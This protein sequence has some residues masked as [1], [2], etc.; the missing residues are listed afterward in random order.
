MSQI[1]DRWMR[2]MDATKERRARF[3]TVNTRGWFEPDS[4]IGMGGGERWREDPTSTGYPQPPVY[5]GRY[6][7]ADEE[8][9]PVVQPPHAH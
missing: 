4:Y 7:R 9:P 6:A 5:G 2:E 8:D 1:D 3:R